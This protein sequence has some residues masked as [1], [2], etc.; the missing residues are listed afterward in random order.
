MLVWLPVCCVGCVVG[1]DGGTWACVMVGR[2]SSRY[3]CT[4]R[5]GLCAGF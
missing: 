4:K 1:E 3:R 2:S 5:L